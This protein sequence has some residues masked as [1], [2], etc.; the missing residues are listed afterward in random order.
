MSLPVLGM[1]FLYMHFPHYQGVIVFSAIF[2]LA[3]KTAR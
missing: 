1:L 2:G 3:L